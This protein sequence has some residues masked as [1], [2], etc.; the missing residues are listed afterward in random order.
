MVRARF[1]SYVKQYDINFGS[2]SG[3]SRSCPGNPRRGTIFRVQV[4]FVA[5]SFTFRLIVVC[6]IRTDEEV[7]RAPRAILVMAKCGWGNWHLT[8][9]IGSRAR[10]CLD[11]SCW[12]RDSRS[13][14]LY[15]MW[16]VRREGSSDIEMP[17]LSLYKHFSKSQSSIH[18]AVTNT[19]RKGR[20]HL[21]SGFLGSRARE[22][23]SGWDVRD[24]LFDPQSKEKRMGGVRRGTGTIGSHGIVL[25]RNYVD[26]TDGVKVTYE[27]VGRFWMQSLLSLL[28]LLIDWPLIFDTFCDIW[29]VSFRKG[30]PPG[31]FSFLC[32]NFRLIIDPCKA[33]SISGVKSKLL[34]F[35]NL[36]LKFVYRFGSSSAP[37]TIKYKLH[38]NYNK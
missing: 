26:N 2:K 12:A 7:I 5:P 31:Q 22:L 14:K 9:I 11:E 30:L 3:Y 13:W 37:G 17:P 29:P 34:K 1:Q 33:I 15:S 16:R 25:Q 24:V 38:A 28:K 36:F 10:T 35:K 4:W 8:R 19:G 32:S 18:L 27:R 23:G 21:R 6:R 20:S